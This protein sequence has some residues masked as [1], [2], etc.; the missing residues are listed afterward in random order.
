MVALLH[1][2]LTPGR[3][4]LSKGAIKCFH[5]RHAWASPPQDHAGGIL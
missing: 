1:R 2:L 5:S 3:W 4:V